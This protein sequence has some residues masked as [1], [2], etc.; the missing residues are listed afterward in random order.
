M[1]PLLT[2]FLQGAPAIPCGLFFLFSISMSA[3]TISVRKP[4]VSF[5]KI[6][7]R[8]VGTRRLQGDDEDE[9]EEEEKGGKEKE[10]DEEEEKGEK[11]EAE[12]SSSG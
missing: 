12:E 4:S 7:S 11:E 3:F 2:N 1:D 6:E 10:K 5:R 8:S 9:D